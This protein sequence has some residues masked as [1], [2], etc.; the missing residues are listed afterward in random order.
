MPLNVWTAEST[1]DD[2]FFT[3]NISR[4]LATSLTGVLNISTRTQ[5]LPDDGGW[6]LD[7]QVGENTH[8]SLTVLSTELFQ[9][10]SN[11]VYSLI[12]KDQLFDVTTRYLHLFLVFVCLNSY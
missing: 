5:R 3:S 12:I 4:H 9:V 10:I 1:L 6:L 2:H 11:S 7:V 8:V